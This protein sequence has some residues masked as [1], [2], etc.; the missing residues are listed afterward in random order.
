LKIEYEHVANCA[1][2]REGLTIVEDLHLTMDD[3]QRVEFIFHSASMQKHGA[4]HAH[5]TITSKIGDVSGLNRTVA[6]APDR[7]NDSSAY[8]TSETYELGFATAIGCPFPPNATIEL[9][10]VGSLKAYVVP[11]FSSADVRVRDGLHKYRFQGPQLGDLQNVTVQHQPNSWSAVAAEEIWVLEQLTLMEESTTRAF[12]FEFTKVR[13]LHP[14]EAQTVGPA[15]EGPS[16]VVIGRIIE[17]CFENEVLHPRTTGRAFAR[18]RWTSGN[19]TP[20]LKDS[21]ELPDS[22]WVWDDAWQVE[23]G[24]DEIGRSL[25]DGWAYAMMWDGTWAAEKSWN[26]QVRRR[27]WIRVRRKRE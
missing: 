21:F 14:S 2:V 12:T 22:T 15:I 24:M 4:P 16:G 8:S 23:A 7:F 11:A 1:T 10:L 20:R 25:T 9:K 6:A 13:P 18:E 5:A 27:R 19:G 17:E 26:S 3:G